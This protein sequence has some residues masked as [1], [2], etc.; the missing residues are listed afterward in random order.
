MTQYWWTVGLRAVLAIC[1]GLAAIFWPGLTL[2]ILTALFGVF[3]LLD[4]TFFLSAAFVYRKFPNRR[5]VFLWEG[6]FS[7]CA[8]I[9]AFGWPA[10]IPVAIA[11]GV[12]F[13]ALI[14]GVLEIIACIQ[15]RKE[16]PGTGLLGFTGI[17]SIIFGVVL[18]AWPKAAIVS[19]MWLIGAYAILFG[20]ML[21]YLSYKLRKL[22]VAK[23]SPVLQS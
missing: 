7:A 6:I 14:V 13:W 20:L 15:L 22:N 9:F 18:L 21:F 3:A 16:L 5:G 10:L 19:L 23:V 11:Y 2:R 1:F 8:G 4:G 12:A 17:M